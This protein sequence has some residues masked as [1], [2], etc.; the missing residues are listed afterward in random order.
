MDTDQL[1]PAL[2]WTQDKTLH[3]SFEYTESVFRPANLGS[4]ENEPKKLSLV[5]L[6]NLAFLPVDLKL[7][8]AFEKLLNASQDPFAGRQTLHQND[9]VVGIP[10][11]TV[12]A[13]LKLFV[14]VIQKDVCQ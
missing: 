8:F 12:S 4:F 5:S 6:P 7:E 13:F 11:E 3:P 14:E 1:L 10:N 2:S 9:E